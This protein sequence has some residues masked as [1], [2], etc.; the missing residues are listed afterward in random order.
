MCTHQ[1]KL[2]PNRFQFLFSF[3]NAFYCFVTWNLLE[4][5][6]YMNCII[7]YNKESTREKAGK[8]S[9]GYVSYE[10][11]TNILIAIRF[12]SLLVDICSVQ[13]AL[14]YLISSTLKTYLSEYMVTVIGKSRLTIAWACLWRYIYSQMK[15][16]CCRKKNDRNKW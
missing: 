1:F 15:M 2:Y 14:R 4:K 6:Q 9:V 12:G 3:L 16:H 5:E 8:V 7:K 13:Y 10:S 11:A